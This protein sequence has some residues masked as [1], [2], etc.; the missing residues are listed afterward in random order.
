[1]DD[2]SYEAVPSE[3]K[4][5]TNECYITITVDEENANLP[6]LGPPGKKLKRNAQ[7]EYNRR[8]AISSAFYVTCALGTILVILSGMAGVGVDEDRTCRAWCSR[9]ALGSQPH[10]YIGFILFLL[11]SFRTQQSYKNYVSGQRSFYQIQT[12]VRS[13]VH[14]FLDVIPRKDIS[15]EH[16]ARI[17]A[18]LIAFPYALTADVRKDRDFGTYQHNLR[19]R[20]ERT[21]QDPDKRRHGPNSQFGISPSIRSGS[22][23]SDV[24]GVLWRAT[25]QSIFQVALRACR[26][27]RAIQRN[28]T[29]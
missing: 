14:L 29:Y 15:K 23:R 2:P 6:T 9:F 16:R 10:A 5:V 21:G 4:E 8:P 28:R 22:N 18:H 12:R 27:V 19:L 24:A 1:M 17:L 13:F 26:A 20:R 7:I 25:T 3:D 11:M